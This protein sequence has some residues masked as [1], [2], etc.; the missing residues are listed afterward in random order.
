MSKFEPEATKQT[1][2][3]CRHSDK[4]CVLTSYPGQIRCILFDQLVYTN[5]TECLEDKDEHKSFLEGETKKGWNEAE[6][7]AGIKDLS[8]RVREL[9]K[10]ALFKNLRA[11][12]GWCTDEPE[13]RKFESFTAEDGHKCHWE[14][15]RGNGWSSFSLIDDTMVELN[16]LRKKAEKKA[17][18]EEAEAKQKKEEPQRKLEETI[19]LFNDI[20][21]KMRTSF[22]GVDLSDYPRA[23]EAFE[24]ATDMLLRIQSGEIG[25]VS[26]EKKEEPIRPP[27]PKTTSGVEILTDK[28]QPTV[29]ERFKALEEKVEKVSEGNAQLGSLAAKLCF[30]FKELEKAVGKLESSDKK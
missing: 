23:Q 20:V 6:I 19:S 26:D 27:M 17:E 2:W 5:Q 15:K 14:Y 3:N 30:R 13:V 16:E 29:E 25:K 21:Y 8:E 12:G 7:K 22:R 1:C 9:T 11:G 28:P 4:S 18:K 10:K 24:Y